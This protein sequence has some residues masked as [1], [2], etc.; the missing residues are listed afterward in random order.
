MW[1]KRGLNEKMTKDLQKLYDR[2]YAK[3]VQKLDQLLFDL[4]LAKERLARMELLKEMQKENE[5]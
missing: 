2:E 4:Q 1:N 5:K 3:L